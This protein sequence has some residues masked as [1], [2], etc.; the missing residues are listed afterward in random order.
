MGT[1]R[2]AAAVI[3]ASRTPVPDVQCNLLPTQLCGEGC[4]WHTRSGLAAA[5]TTEAG[6]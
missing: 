6:T 4:T 2:A 3:L 1:P 5:L